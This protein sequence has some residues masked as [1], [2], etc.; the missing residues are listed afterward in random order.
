MDSNWF[1]FAG[2]TKCASSNS[3]DDLDDNED[4]DAT[5][6]VNGNAQDLLPRSNIAPQITE[7]LIIEL[8]DKNWKVRNEALTKV[9]AIIQDAGLIKPTVSDL[10]QALAQRLSD[11]NTKIAQTSVNICEAMAKAMGPPCKQYVRVLLPGFL[12]GKFSEGDLQNK[13]VWGV[14]QRYITFVFY[15][16]Q[17]RNLVFFVIH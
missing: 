1:L 7:A 15:I 8:S 2:V 5:A 10:P 12:Q 4:E 16:N 9:S 14:I 17:M 6:E 3:L 11:S 13:D